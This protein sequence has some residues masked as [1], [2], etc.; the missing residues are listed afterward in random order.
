MIPFRSFKKNPSGPITG[1]GWAAG[2]ISGPEHFCR[3]FSG[4]NPAKI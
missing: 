2:K 1:S 3:N 4:R